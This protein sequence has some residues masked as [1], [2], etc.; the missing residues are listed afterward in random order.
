MDTNKKLFKMTTINA[1]MKELEEFIQNVYWGN[2]LTKDEKKKNLEEGLVN[3][4][5]YTL[6]SEEGDLVQE[7]SQSQGLLLTKNGYILMTAHGLGYKKHLVKEIRI[8]TKTGEYPLEKICFCEGIKD[9]ALIKA[10]M[11]GPD[12]ARIYSIF[13]TTNMQNQLGT[14]MRL[15]DKEI[16]VHECVVSNRYLDTHAYDSKN[17]RFIELQNV[18]LTYGVSCEGDSGSILSTVDS[19]IIGMVVASCGKQI[20]MIMPMDST[21]NLL[22]KYIHDNALEITEKHP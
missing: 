18:L 5:V 11:Q 22:A 1:D 3:I 16:H 6:Y 14:W 2:H 21:L 4:E 8:I 7:T 15:K 9:T 12:K 20:M 10:D 17:N 19:D 13:N